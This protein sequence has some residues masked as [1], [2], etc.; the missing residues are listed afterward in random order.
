MYFDM[1][2]SYR[3]VSFWCKVTWQRH[4]ESETRPSEIK[5]S[6][7]KTMLRHNEITHNAHPATRIS[8]YDNLW[9]DI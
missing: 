1:Y 7:T 4:T 2:M 8:L 6:I 5:R 3:W 9:F